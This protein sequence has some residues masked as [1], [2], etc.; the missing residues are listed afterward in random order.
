[1]NKTDERLPRAVAERRPLR[2]DFGRPLSFQLPTPG[3]AG[4]AM[5][6]P[7]DDELHLARQNG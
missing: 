2:T 6:D 5:V 1:M 7:F 3:Q 4:Y